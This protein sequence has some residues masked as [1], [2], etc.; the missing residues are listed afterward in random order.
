MPA[1]AQRAPARSRRGFCEGGRQLP[2]ELAIACVA[3]AGLVAPVAAQQG[4]VQVTGSA[5]ALSGD[6]ERLAGQSRL[7]PDF[8]VTWF[9]PRRWGSLQME[10]RGTRRG[11]EPHLGRAYVAW[12]DVKHR[13]AIWTF[14]GGDFYFTPVVS[15]YRF[16][17]LSTPVVTLAGGSVTARTTRSSVSLVA[18]K[19]TA[20]RNIFGSDPDTLGQNVALARATHKAFNWLNVNVRASS[21][22]TRDVKEFNYTI[23]ASDQAGGGIHATIGPTLHVVADG[24]YVSYRRFGSNERLHDFSTTVGAS[25]VHARGWLQA[26]V[27][28]FSPGEFPVVNYSLADRQSAFL[29]GEL[30]VFRS[31]RVLGG[32]EAFRGNLDPGRAA[33]SRVLIPETD[34]SRAFGGLRANF[35]GHTS[36]AVRFERG[37]R[38]TRRNGTGFFN[39]SDTGVTTAELQT[40]LGRFT[41][42]FRASRRENVESL[43]GG[44]YEQ[45]DGTA[46]VFVNLSGDLQVFGTAIATRNV[47]ESGAGSTYYQ[48]GGGGQFQLFNRTMW[49]RLEGLAARNQDMI[50]QALVA[51]ESFNVGVNGQVAHN[52]TL[53]LN[54]F[55]ERS[56]LLTPQSSPWLGR[57]TLRVTRTFPTGAV[58]VP[59]TAAAL[60]PEGRARGTGSIVGSVF[61]DWDGDGIPDPDEGPLE[62]IPVLLGNSA[63]TTSARGDFAFTNVPSGTLRVQVDLAAL[64]VDFDPPSVP[65]L[66]LDLP[67][68]ETRRIAFGLIPLGTVSGRVLRDANSNNVLDPADEP[69]DAAVLVLDGGQR[70]EQVRQG[71]YQFE[72]VRSGR[73]TLELLLESLPEGGT[74]IGQR[75]L[76]VAV[77]REQQSTA[78][79]FLVK[80]DKRPEI[81]KVFPPRSGTPLRGSTKTPPSR[82]PAASPTP[83][84]ATPERRVS[85]PRAAGGRAAPGGFTIQVAALSALTNAR[86]LAAQLEAKGYGAYVVVPPPE[87]ANG[88]YRV[89]VGRY[90][91][92]A[93]AKRA[94][95]KLERLRGE[96]LWVTRVR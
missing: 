37:D 93:A 38:R 4:S 12:R 54:L 86:A 87:D 51:R 10:L 62:G 45:T 57:S 44:G 36:V 95:P 88:L 39:D 59:G 16:T 20:W 52:T 49:L 2:R 6:P 40:R 50:S 68:G 7:E 63:A 79:D 77:T 56:P 78:V 46:Q 75:L 91:S 25:F 21:I 70:S 61:A 84:A 43:V 34:G 64:P 19:A 89:R 85:P 73:H 94:L 96:K 48:V 22:R 29:A 9:Q 71:R 23:A 83:S 31:V 72:S 80:V 26:N 5:Q 35:L 24:G 1:F 81:R 55:A 82:S 76:E 92:R 11:R 41:S 13:G 42:F 58:R 3:L 28:R 32:W 90:L 30:D 15:E 65:T 53:G 8:G 14:E 47:L 66:D 33:L 69:I 74:I 27:S 18:G 67:R 17:N 60:L